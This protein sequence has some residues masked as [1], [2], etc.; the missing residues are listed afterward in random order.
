[1]VIKARVVKHSWSISHEFVDARGCS[2]RKIDH[3]RLK[4][5]PWLRGTC[6]ICLN[7]KGLKH[8]HHDSPINYSHSQCISRKS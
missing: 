6:L 7:Y 2:N 4:A 3:K 8:M 5:M 1:M